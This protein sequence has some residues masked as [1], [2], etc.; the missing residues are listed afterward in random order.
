MKINTY[1]QYIRFFFFFFPSLKIRIGISDLGNKTFVK[2]VLLN[3]TPSSI[4]FGNHIYL[5]TY[6]LSSFYRTCGPRQRPCVISITVGR[7]L[8]ISFMMK[9]KESTRLLR[10]NRGFYTGQPA[11]SRNI[12]V[13]LS[14]SPSFFPLSST[15]V[16]HLLLSHFRYRSRSYSPF[17]FPFSFPSFSS[18]RPPF[19]VL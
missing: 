7:T 6:F 8:D 16:F 10:S 18:S 15:A 9:T 17:L 4:S 14:P 2:R 12:N 3:I 5:L 19:P 13:S 11:S 1:V